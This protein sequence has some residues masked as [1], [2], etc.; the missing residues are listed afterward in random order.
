MDAL[1]YHSYACLGDDK[2]PTDALDRMATWVATLAE[3]GFTLRTTGQGPVA[4]AVEP[5]SL[6]TEIYI[7][8]KKFD[9]IESP[10]NKYPS[11]AEEI[12]ASCHP[13]S[14]ETLKNG[15]RLF[16][17]RNVGLLLGLDLHSHARALLVWTPDGVESSRDITWKTGF[18]G[19]PMRVAGKALIPIFNF[20]KPE[21]ESRLET[22]LYQHQT[23]Y[24]YPID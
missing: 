16:L 18:T 19:H 2:T 13:T 12:A 14:W 20:G 22:F 3:A 1:R 17:T 6:K 8:F 9:N 21:V 10:F 5:K 4:K 7:P 24:K 15:Q 23:R 11:E